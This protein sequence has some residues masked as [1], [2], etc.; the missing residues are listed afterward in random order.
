MATVKAPTK[1]TQMNAA[2][3]SA[4]IRVSPAVARLLARHDRQSADQ[5]DGPGNGQAVPGSHQSSRGR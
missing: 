4:Q 1:V 3:K 5:R 2:T